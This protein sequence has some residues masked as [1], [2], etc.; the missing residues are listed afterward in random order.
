M[1]AALNTM[2]KILFPPRTSQALVPGWVQG[3]TDAAEHG[4]GGMGSSVLL[5]AFCPEHHKAPRLV[6]PPRP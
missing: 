2:V 6:K 1:A 4:G 3:A 5:A